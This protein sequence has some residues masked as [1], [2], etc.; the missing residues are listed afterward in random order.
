MQQSLAVQEPVVTASAC[1]LDRE[2]ARLLQVIV[3]YL[4]EYNEPLL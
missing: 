1:I 2:L 3:E 4:F